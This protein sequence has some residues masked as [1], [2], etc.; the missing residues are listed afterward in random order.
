MFHAVSSIISP[1]LHA[2]G[3]SHAHDE[4]LWSRM[5]TSLD[6]I[7][8]RSDPASVVARFGV[9]N[10]P[11][12]LQSKIKSA[13]PFYLHAQVKLTIVSL[14]FYFCLYARLLN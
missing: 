14:F 8:R 12:L 3:F 11:N 2:M 13:A 4:L 7:D 6:G 10:E 9:A 5:F 1:T